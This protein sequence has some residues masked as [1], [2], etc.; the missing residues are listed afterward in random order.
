M[1]NWGDSLRVRIDPTL[2]TKVDIACAFYKRNKSQ[3][4]RMVL[5]QWIDQRVRDNH[6]LARMF[7]AVMPEYYRELD[8]D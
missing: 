4:L 3:L 7:K 1:K 2:R 6:R 5:E 8:Q